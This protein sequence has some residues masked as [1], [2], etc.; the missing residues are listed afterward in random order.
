MWLSVNYGDKGSKKFTDVFVVEICQ[1]LQNLHDKRDRYTPSGTALLVFL[2]SKWLHDKWK[3]GAET[4]R[5]KAFR[6]FSDQ[7][8]EDLWL[9]VRSLR[10]LY[11]LP[12]KPYGDWEERGISAGHEYYCRHNL[13]TGYNGPKVQRFLKRISH[14]RHFYG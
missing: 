13:I 6:A 1:T 3:P 8:L 4:E 7:P 5:W 9:P 11:S 2:P 14:S 12:D 10:V